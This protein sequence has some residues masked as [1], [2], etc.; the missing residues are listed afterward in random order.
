MINCISF[1]DPFGAAPSRPGCILCLRRKPLDNQ[2]D[3][4]SW[5]MSI[6]R[7]RLI[8]DRVAELLAWRLGLTR[9]QHSPKL[10][11]LLH[12]GLLQRARP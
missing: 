6:G 1:R 7:N 8:S 12:S 10:S 11:K 3:A 9:R 2:R 4:Q 5:E